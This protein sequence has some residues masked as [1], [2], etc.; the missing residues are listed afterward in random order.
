MNADDLLRPGYQRQ[1]VANRQTADGFYAETTPDGRL[2][3]FGFYRQG[4]PRGWMIEDGRATREQIREGHT[5]EWL[6]DMIDTVYHQAEADHCVCSFCGKT[7]AEVATLIAGPDS[8]TY[9]C[10]ECIEVCGRIV[11]ESKSNQSPA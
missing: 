5:E 10:D 7:S 1:T 4:E 11:A 6:R 2:T 8:Y 9:I 3:H